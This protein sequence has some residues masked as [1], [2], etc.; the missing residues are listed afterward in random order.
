MFHFIYSLLCGEMVD[1]QIGREL[2]RV[3]PRSIAFISTTTVGFSVISAQLKDELGCFGKRKNELVP[4]ASAVTLIVAFAFANGG[5]VS[6]VSDFTPEMSAGKTS[7]ESDETHTGAWLKQRQTG[8]KTHRLG[9][10]QLKRS[11]KWCT[12]AGVYMRLN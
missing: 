6:H 2:R 7:P 9:G 1:S 8:K 11:D 4:V 5:P 3:Q 12:Y 10:S